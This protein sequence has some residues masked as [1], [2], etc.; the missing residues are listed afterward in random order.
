M[1]TSLFNCLRAARPVVLAAVLVLAHAALA[2]ANEAYRLNISDRI[3]IKVVEW[4]PSQGEFREWTALAG[5]ASIGPNGSVPIPFLGEA[6]A[7]GKSAAELGGDI[8]KGLQQVF[9]LNIAPDVTVAI[10]AYA[11]VF[12]AGDVQAPGQFAFTPG[13]N[14]IKAVSLAGGERIATDALLRG[15]RD[16]ISASGSAE[17][18]R[19]KL[20]RLQARRARLTAE[21][22][23]DAQVPVPPELSAVVDGAAVVAVEQ[24]ILRA[25]ASRAQAQAASLRELINLLNGELTTLAQ[26]QTTVERQLEIAR[27]ELGNIKSLASDGLAANTRVSAIE[28]N[29][30]ELETRLLDIGT[31]ILRAQQSISDTDRN[32]AALDN[33]RT[34]ELTAEL[35]QVDGQIDELNVQ[36]TTQQALIT[37][38]IILGAAQQAEGDELV[39]Y[40]YSIVRAGSETPGTETTE[41]QPGDVIRVTRKIRV[42]G[43]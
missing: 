2:Q 28:Q 17:V 27:R 38:A 18:A 23:G 16:L 35:Q 8:S 19:G 37:D 29:V 20:Q 42:A 21:L 26:K 24:A 11:P 41:L 30:A 3:A 4:L 25:N 32:L 9:G 40:S 39:A 5:E 13:L 6:A 1:R 34:A 31:A 15:E 12:V 43:P 33:D 10:V 22:D 14:V 7:A 36:L